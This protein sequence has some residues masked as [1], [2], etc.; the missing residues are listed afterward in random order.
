MLETYLVS[1]GVAVRPIW[2]RGGEVLEDLAPRR[3]GGGA[4]PVAFVDHDQ[5]EEPRRELAIGLLAFLRSGDRLIQAEIDLV[6]GVDAARELGHRAAEGA[7]IVGHRL[8]DEHVAVGK[9]QDAPLA[10]RLPQPP[11]DLEGGVGL[12]RA[13]GHD[14]QD[15]VLPLGDGL[16]RRV[17]GVHLIVARRL[18]AAVLEVVLKDDPLGFGRQALPDPIARP[19]IGG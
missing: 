17:D 14:E 10:S 2:G 5:I 15:A 6:G 7:E 16:D 18:A 3:I 8:V 12:A 1:F 4:A 9:E 13:R 11:D 19:Q